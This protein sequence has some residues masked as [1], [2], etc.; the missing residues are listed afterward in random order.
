MPFLLLTNA[1]SSR[2]HM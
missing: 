1:V 2:D